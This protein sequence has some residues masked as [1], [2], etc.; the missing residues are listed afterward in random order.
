MSKMDLKTKLY[1]FITGA[2][3]ENTKEYTKPKVEKN[4]VYVFGNDDEFKNYFRNYLGVD[5]DNNIIN[6][7]IYTKSKYGAVIAFKGLC[8]YIITKHMLNYDIKELSQDEID[9][10]HKRGKITQLEKVKEWESCDLCAPGDASGSA[11]Y[12]CEIFNYNCHECLLEY[13][14][15]KTEYQPM[16][17]KLVNSLINM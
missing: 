1:L 3:I 15:H 10:I 4:I 11:A 2:V 17:F 16:E 14:S 13:A 8:D 9:N 5:V 7:A 6:T 12:R